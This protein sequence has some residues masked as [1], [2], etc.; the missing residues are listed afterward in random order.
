MAALPSSGHAHPRTRPRRARHVV[1]GGR[2]GRPR[3]APTGWAL[4]LD[5]GRS[6][7]G[8]DRRVRNHRRPAAARA[9][10]GFVHDF[11]HQLVHRTDVRSTDRRSRAA[12][13]YP[14]RC[15]RSRSCSR[16]GRPGRGPGRGSDAASGNPRR[17]P[18]P[19]NGSSASSRLPSRST[20]SARR[21]DRRRRRD[22]DR[23]L[24]HAAE[25]GPEAQLARPGQHRHGRPDTAALGEL[26]VDP[27]DDAHQPL[28]ILGRRT[29]SSATIGSGE[30]SWSQRELVET[31]RA[32]NGCSIS[33]T[34]SRS[35]S[36][37]RATASS[38]CQPVLASTRIGPSYTA[39][40]ASQRR[41][42]GR[43]A[44]L[45]LQGR[46]IGRPARPLGDDRR[47]RRGRG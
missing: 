18:G 19:R 36:G 31:A 29:L 15:S 14:R 3:E 10:R 11:V 20:Q 32:G 26:H 7:P 9:G 12:V 16:G 4:V 8:N 40:T 43:T 13:R 28:E 39:R 21:R 23:R 44:A 5:S 42:V 1:R 2:S 41:E 38:G 17:A 24:L 34:P 6:L 25:E 46:E 37:R 27:G 22:R 35:S 33:S 45:D 47:A 30:R